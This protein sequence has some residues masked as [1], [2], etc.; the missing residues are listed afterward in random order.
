MTHVFDYLTLLVIA[1]LAAIGYRRGFL[2]ELG[3]LLGLVISGLVALRFFGPVSFWL[4]ANTALNPTFLTV[5]SFL[6]IFLPVLILIRFL[7][8]TLQVFMLSRGIRS[9]NKALGL[10]F[11][12]LKGLF[13]II[14]LVWAVDLAPNPEYFQS[15]RERSYAYHQL[16]QFRRWMVDSFGMEVYL[17]KG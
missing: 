7:S 11:G 3:R 14:I 13:A 15:V 1:V 16:T 9:S 17:G 4:Q 2:E 5:V 12:T 8:G 10:M 6:A